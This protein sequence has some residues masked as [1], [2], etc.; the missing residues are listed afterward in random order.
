[1]CVAC[2]AMAEGPQREGFT[3]VRIEGGSFDD[4]DEPEWGVPADTSF[5]SPIAQPRGESTDETVNSTTTEIAQEEANRA[6]EIID[7]I[8]NQENMRDDGTVAP[9]N[10]DESNAQFYN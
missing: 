2:E 4:N 6:A 9:S 5:F 1:M 3:N 8:L 10:Y 7:S